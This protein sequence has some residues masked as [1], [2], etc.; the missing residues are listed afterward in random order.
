M[1][2]ITEI[3]E[4]TRLSELSENLDILYKLGKYD[5]NVFLVNKRIWNH[6]LDRIDYLYAILPDDVDD[7]KRYLELLRKTRKLIFGSTIKDG[8]DTEEIVIFLKCIQAMTDI[9]I[10]E[11]KISDGLPR[12]YVLEKLVLYTNTL[13]IK[14]PYHIFQ[15]VICEN[16]EFIS[17]NDECQIVLRFTE[18]GPSEVE[19]QELQSLYSLVPNMKLEAIDYD[20]L[21]KLQERKGMLPDVANPEYYILGRTNIEEIITTFAQERTIV[22]QKYWKITDKM[23]ISILKTT[24]RLNIQ[25]AYHEEITDQEKILDLVAS[26]DLP[27]LKLIVFA[28]L[29]RNAE[30]LIKKYSHLRTNITFADL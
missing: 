13:K 23:L 2:E 18:V 25:F 8:S 7:T 12:H 24:E 20:S 29:T 15:Y 14:C 4:I 19:I 6:K 16:Y 10:K 3:S 5:K 28:Y 30:D 26:L 9:V 17:E 1:T 27:N 22:C 11:I 21:K